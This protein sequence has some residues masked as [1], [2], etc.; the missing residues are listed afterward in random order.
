[1]SHSNN[2]LFRSMESWLKGLL[3]IAT[4]LVSLLALDSLRMLGEPL[5]GAIILIETHYYYALFGLLLPFGFRP[6]QRPLLEC[7]RAV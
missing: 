7:L 1:M 5:L 6:A 3:V 4:L 2:T